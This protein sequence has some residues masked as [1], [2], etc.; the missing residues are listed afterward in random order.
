MKKDL[1]IIKRIQKSWYVDLNKKTLAQ[2]FESHQEA[3]KWATD[4]FPTAKVY[5]D[6]TPN[7]KLLEALRIA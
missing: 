3:L 5:T 4:T 2:E 6:N 1:I 7:I